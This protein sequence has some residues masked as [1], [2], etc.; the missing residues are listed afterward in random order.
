M[1][2]K[3]TMV[4]NQVLSDMVYTG[5]EEIKD[6][7]EKSIIDRIIMDLN[8]FYTKKKMII[9]HD[10]NLLEEIESM[11][12]TKAQKIINYSKKRNYSMSILI[13]AML[14]YCCN[15]Y[16]DD[17]LKK[18]FGHLSFVKILNECEVKHRTLTMNSYKLID[19]LFN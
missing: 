15:I 18:K 8:K 5:F 17:E 12:L 16:C 1:I 11:Y 9:I 6:K 7:K 2:D 3:N 13:M 19:K 4:I 10:K 14:D